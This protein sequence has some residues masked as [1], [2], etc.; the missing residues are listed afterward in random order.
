MLGCLPSSHARPT[1][2][3]WLFDRI[4]SAPFAT[5]ATAPDRHQ[6]SGEATSY[7]DHALLR[8]SALIDFNI[9][10]TRIS[11]FRQL[12]FKDG[13]G[14]SGNTVGTEAS[15]QFE[16][17]RFAVTTNGQFGRLAVE[18][19]LPG[20]D[21]GIWVAVRMNAGILETPRLPWR[22]SSLAYY[23]GNTKG[24]GAV[25]VIGLDLMRSLVQ[26]AAGGFNVGLVGRWVSWPQAERGINENENMLISFA[27]SFLWSGA[28]GQ[29]EVGIPL[30]I[31]IDKETLPS[32]QLLNPNELT[33]PAINISASFKL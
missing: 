2:Q 15:L 21:R 17:G 7:T 19:L 22:F 28:L 27:P 10:E 1:R 33:A 24:V 18:V 8:T 12:G 16:L 23:A 11:V 4:A 25:M 5:P 13:F 30:R 9:L 26:S 31:W 6:L 3:G 14:G 29:L 32:G 20:A